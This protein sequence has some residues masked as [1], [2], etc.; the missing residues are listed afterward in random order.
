MACAYLIFYRVQAEDPAAFVAYY[1]DHHL[2]LVRQFPKILS[3]EFHVADDEEAPFLIVVRLVFANRHDLE[4][5]LR[6]PE[7]LSA[8]ADMKRFPAYEGDVLRQIVRIEPAS[9]AMTT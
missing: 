7:R 8:H 2:P 4:V 3:V 9:E 5:A 1:R 6:S